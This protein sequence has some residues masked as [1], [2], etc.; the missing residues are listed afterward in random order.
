MTCAAAQAG[1][2][3]QASPRYDPD[4]QAL[5]SWNEHGCAACTGAGEQ[6]PALLQGLRRHRRG[7]TFTLAAL[8]YDIGHERE[9]AREHAMPHGCCVNEAALAQAV[10]QD[11]AV[12]AGQLAATA[13]PAPPQDGSEAQPAPCAPEALP[14]AA[15][16]AGELLRTILSPPPAAAGAGTADAA[17]AEKLPAAC[18]EVCRG[19]LLLTVL[20]ALSAGADQG[21]PPAARWADALSRTVLVRLREAAGAVYRSLVIRGGGRALNAMFFDHARQTPGA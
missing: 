11:A 1:L 13:L 2:R 17:A 3:A 16:A 10:G 8:S 6:L 20:Q 9:H 4:I 19:T 21:Q 14:Q 5:G 12:W 15:P 18:G 7:H